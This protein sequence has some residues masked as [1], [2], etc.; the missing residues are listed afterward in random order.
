MEREKTLPPP[1]ELL[2]FRAPVLNRR[3]AEPQVPGNE[4]PR[5]LLLAALCKLPYRV[6]RCLSDAGAEVIVLGAREAIGLSYSRYCRKFF[7]CVSRIDGDLNPELAIEINRV[8]N[9]YSIDLVVAGDAPSTRSLIEIVE[10]LD[11][12][13]F[14]MPD[15]EA[16]D[17]LN[18]KWRFTQLCN[19]MGITCP[20][21]RFF[22]DAKR[23]CAEY[24]HAGLPFPLIAK[25]LSR[26]S[27]IG[28]VVAESEKDIRKL[29][30]ISYSPIIV[31]DYIF[32][33]DIGT[34]MFC[35]DGKIEAFLVHS[36][37]K[38]TYTAY[39]EPAIYQSVARIARR[40]RLS[41]IFNFDMRLTA[42]GEVYFLEC[43]PRVFYKIAMSMLVGVNFLGAGFPWRRPAETPSLA[44]P[45]AIRF[46][47]AVLG[48][49]WKLDA[50]ARRVLGFLLEDPL[51]YLRE[52]LGFERK[53]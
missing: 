43:N 30:R 48:A 42:D 20:E 21:S 39:D 45:V 16:F 33:E 53:R 2:S 4:I 23:L 18:N 52:N 44:G 37:I 12:P 29:S 40:L 11:A 47:K 32:G 31:Q 1:E 24:Y 3:P 35:R 41:G 13:C 6:L 22:D 7:R 49:P 25:P 19:E 36:Y 14:P 8:V 9:A 50:A 46:P 27:G 10:D 26:D 5:V 28:C 34:S 15:L 17:L 38:A 51:P